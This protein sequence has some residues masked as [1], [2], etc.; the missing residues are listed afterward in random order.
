MRRAIVRLIAVREAR[1][2]LRDRRTM[3]LILGLPVLM[4]PLFVGV[5]I[6][7]VSMLKGK[8]L[9][10]G[11][12]GAEHLPQPGRPGPHPFPPLFAGD[13]FVDAYATP[14]LPDDP[15]A[16]AG[17]LTVTRLD[18]A[19]DAALNELLSSREVDVVVVVEPGLAERL[20][21]GERPVV[22]VMGR[23][24]EENSKLAVRRVMGVLRKWAAGVKTARF[25]RAG[26]PADFDTPVDL[27]DPQSDKPVDKKLADEL[28]DVL[29]KV[30]PLLL[31]MW[32]LTGA[33][34]PAIDMTAGEKER[35]T[36]ETLLISPAERTEIVAGKFLAV[37][38]LAFG[39]AVWNVMLMVLAVGVAQVLFPYPLLSMAGLAGCVVAALPVA[40]LLAAGCITLGVFA[41]STKEGN[42]YMVPMF[43]LVLPLAYWS[44]APG[45][46]LDAQ[47]S[48]VPVTNALL[49]QQ[50]LLSVRPDPFPWQHVPA[51]VVSMSACIGLA[52]WAAVVQFRREAVLFREAEQGRAKFS[53]FGRRA[54]KG[55][56]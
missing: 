13:R 55:E 25:A 33:I 56:G 5:G 44:M 41:R 36:M 32:V 27:R 28:R 48:W 24:G 46:E 49:V 43:F 17:R 39:T 3:F 18:P 30:I 52:L 42:Y 29:V 20:E 23:E 8:Q 2:Q 35:G 19:P 26:L 1:D 6:V 54:A 47:M 4:Y 16:A 53:L 14:D 34:Y 12:V 21:R 38:A 45:I 50:R 40:L 51:V 31:T 22:R 37:S 15:E 7:F 11:V 10:V 9:V